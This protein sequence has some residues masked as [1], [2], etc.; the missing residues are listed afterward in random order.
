MSFEH[1]GG[2][3]APPH[4]SQNPTRSPVLVTADRADQHRVTLLRRVARSGRA[5]R[6]G[7]STASWNGMAGG[8]SSSPSAC[9]T[10]VPAWATDRPG[11]DAPWTTKWPYIGGA[12]SRRHTSRLHPLSRVANGRRSYDDAAPTGGWSRN[13][14]VLVLSQRLGWVSGHPRE[15]PP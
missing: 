8:C 7:W 13:R 5:Q 1:V 6:W 3:S 4:A 2:R 14:G 11:I 15:K 12:S 10:D 9:T